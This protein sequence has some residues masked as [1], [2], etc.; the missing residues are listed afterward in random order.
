MKRRLGAV[1]KWPIRE[2]Q[3]GGQR[4]IQGKG[5]GGPSPLLFL[6]QTEAR[7]TRKNFLGDQSSP[8]IS[9]P[10]DPALLVAVKGDC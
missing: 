10:L 6:D 7:R 5:P 9:R 4:R 3:W 1:Q 2:S 8:L